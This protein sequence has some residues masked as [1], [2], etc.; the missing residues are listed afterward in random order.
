MSQNDI[1]CK[2]E[3][4]GCLT[5]PSLLQNLPKNCTPN[6]FQNLLPALYNYTLIEYFL[7]SVD[8]MSYNARLPYQSLSLQKPNKNFSCRDFDAPISPK[9][10]IK[11]NTLDGE[12]VK[13]EDGSFPQETLQTGPKAALSEASTQEGSN[14]CGIPEGVNKSCLKDKHSQNPRKNLPGLVLQRIRTS[15]LAALENK[16]K[17]LSVADEIRLKYVKEIFEKLNKEEIEKFQEYFKLLNKNWKTWKKV[18]DYIHGNEAFSEI[19]QKIIEG[20]LAEEGTLDFNHW[21]TAGKMNQETKQ[22]IERSK[23]WLVI[24]FKEVFKKEK[25]D[26][27][28][29]G[30]IKMEE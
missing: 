20:F 11:L 30:L 7:A 10:F 18:H 14:S 23:E 3:D 28:S 29:S 19:V 1:S 13:L 16:N 9:K 4:E 8:S 15:C 27:L 2:V 21:L 22:V 6:S 5:N 12:K 25:S 24:K 26:K 17:S